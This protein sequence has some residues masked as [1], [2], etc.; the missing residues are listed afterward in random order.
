MMSTLLYTLCSPP[1]VCV[2]LLFILIMYSVDLYESKL[3]FS[4]K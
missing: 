1:S 2:L 3:T 4:F